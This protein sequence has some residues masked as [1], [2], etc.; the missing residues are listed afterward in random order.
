MTTP[1]HDPDLDPASVSAAEDSDLW[2]SFRHWMSTE[3]FGRILRAKKRLWLC[4]GAGALLAWLSPTALS[5][6]ASA[7]IAPFVGLLIGMSFAW[8]VTIT[9]L[10]QTEQGQRFGQWNGGLH[11]RTFVMKY[12]FAIATVFVV[13]ALWAIIGAG[14]FDKIGSLAPAPLKIIGRWPVFALTIFM[15][16][17]MW[18][19]VADV[20]KML[21]TVEWLR[22]D[23]ERELLEAA[24][25]KAAAAAAAAAT[26][27]ATTATVA[28]ASAAN[29]TPRPPTTGVRAEPDPVPAPTAQPEAAPHDREVTAAA[30]PQA[31]A[32]SV[33]PSAASGQQK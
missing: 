21:L 16:L 5:A 32:T 11:F 20:A 10:L 4:A 14:A 25:A 26:V 19:T 27:T 24:A 18:D 3:G 1:R 2:V 6:V 31:R 23:R 15:V 22:R 28:S 30:A 8:S 33:D 17:E 12:V 13:S 29:S 7:A 9:S